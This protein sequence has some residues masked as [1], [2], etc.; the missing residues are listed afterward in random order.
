MRPITSRTN[1]SQRYIHPTGPGRASGVFAYLFFSSLA[2]ARTKERV[3]KY[4]GS[5]PLSVATAR[6]G[7]A[8]LGLLRLVAPNGWLTV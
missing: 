8:W 7:S 1:P 3:L 5:P 6:L 2:E 4:F